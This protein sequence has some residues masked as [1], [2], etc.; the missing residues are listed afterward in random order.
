MILNYHDQ[1]DHVP[2][3]KKTRQDNDMIDPIRLVYAETKVELL[4]PI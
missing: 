2:S 1:S 3:V 4:V